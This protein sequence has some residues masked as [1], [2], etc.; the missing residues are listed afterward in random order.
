M[1]EDATTWVPSIYFHDICQMKSGVGM[2][3]ERPNKKSTL[4]FS[5]DVFYWDM[6]VIMMMMKTVN[7]FL[8]F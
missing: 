5:Q 8:L 7:F 1:E 6:L 2:R 3:L 4:E